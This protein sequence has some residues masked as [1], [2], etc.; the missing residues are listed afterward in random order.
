MKALVIV[1]LI[2]VVLASYVIVQLRDDLTAA[3]EKLIEKRAA[4][5]GWKC[6][7]YTGRTPLKG[8]FRV[9]QK[10]TGM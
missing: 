9:C 10:I 5:L 2:G 3:Q 1:L 8:E 7:D 6:R 4:A